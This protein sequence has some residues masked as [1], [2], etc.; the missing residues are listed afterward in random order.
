MRFQKIE[1]LIICYKFLSNFDFL[2]H[3]GP[4]ELITQ[5]LGHESKNQSL[6]F[7]PWPKNESDY[8]QLQN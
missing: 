5:F 2:T 8:G 3:H 6:V 1:I 4:H 7:D